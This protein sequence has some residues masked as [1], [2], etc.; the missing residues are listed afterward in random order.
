VRLCP[1]LE[2]LFYF[3]VSSHWIDIIHDSCIGEG[4]DHLFTRTEWYVRIQ[5]NVYA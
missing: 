1:P 4:G 3:L 5:F 2:F